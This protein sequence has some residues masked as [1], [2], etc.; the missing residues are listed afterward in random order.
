MDL[1]AWLSILIIILI[2]L[3]IVL[4]FSGLNTTA[5]STG[6]KND[7][8]NSE[9]ENTLNSVQPQN[10]F[11]PWENIPNNPRSEC[12]L[13]TFPSIQADQPFPPTFISEIIDNLEPIDPN[14]N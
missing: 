11:G 10:S 4:G 7:S 2:L 6:S 12:L 8:N 1:S 9:I 3:F 13:Y 5:G 14:T